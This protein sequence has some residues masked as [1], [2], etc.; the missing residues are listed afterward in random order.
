MLLFR[1]LKQ[2]IEVQRKAYDYLRLVKPRDKFIF[3]QKDVFQLKFIDFDYLRRLMSNGDFSD[4]CQAVNLVYKIPV[5][6][7]PFLRV[8]TFFGL[9]NHIIQKLELAS[10][11]ES[12]LD[13][14]SDSNK[15]IAMK[16]SGVSRLNQFGIY[17]LI[18]SLSKGDKTKHEYFENLTYEKIYFLITFT[19]IQGTVNGLFEKNYTDILKTTK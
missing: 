7:I 10:E 15:E 12:K 5:F 8:N 1:L 2:P 4:I 11:R 14:F 9:V 3:K 17:N 19:T 13:H 16:M 18:D 6:L